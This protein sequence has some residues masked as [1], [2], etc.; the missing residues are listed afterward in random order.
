MQTTQSRDGFC[1]FFLYVLVSLPLMNAKEMHECSRSAHK[2]RRSKRLWEANQRATRPHV[3]RTKPQNRIWKQDG[4]Q[5]QKCQKDMLANR[6]GNPI[7]LN[8]K[9]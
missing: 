2:S 3:T 8:C 1:I 5:S 6:W 4:W 7:W 9:R